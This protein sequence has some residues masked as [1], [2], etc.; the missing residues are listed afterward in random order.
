MKHV[1]AILAL[2]ALT[3][4]GVDGEPIP[5]SMNANIGLGPGGVSA[6]TGLTVTKGPVAVGWG[7]GL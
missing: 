4:C 7:V 2:A 6:S 5:P 1:L 3:G